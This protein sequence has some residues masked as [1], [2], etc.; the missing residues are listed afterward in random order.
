[1]ENE[2]YSPYLNIEQLFCFCGKQIQ[3][4]N[5]K[6]KILI[7]TDDEWNGYHWLFYQFTDNT[8]EIKELCEGGYFHDRIQDP[9]NFVLLG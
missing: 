1:M 7:T 3:K 2:T 8:E 5:G 4:W 9:E 6:K